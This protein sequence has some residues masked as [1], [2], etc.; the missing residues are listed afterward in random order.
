MLVMGN[1]ACTIAVVS[2]FMCFM[3]MGSMVPGVMHLMT[4]MVMP[5]VI[6]LRM[7]T[8]VV[9]VVVFMCRIAGSGFVFSVVV[10]VIHR[11][12][13]LLWTVLERSDSGIYTVAD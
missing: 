4:C 3:L 10:I 8:L 7:L 12:S 6:S 9:H 1:V 5:S 11:P 13:P 2:P